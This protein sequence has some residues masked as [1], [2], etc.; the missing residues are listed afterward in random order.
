MIKLEGLT[1]K[2]AAIAQLLWD[3]ETEASLLMLIKCLP[4]REDQAMAKTLVQLMIH[5]SWE[6]DRGLDEFKEQALEAIDLAR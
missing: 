6:Q 3:C 1:K 5:E 4:T 2:Q